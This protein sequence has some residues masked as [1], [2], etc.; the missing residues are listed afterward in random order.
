MRKL[1]IC[2]LTLSATAFTA[3]PASAAVE[4]P[5]RAEKS[6]ADS[7][8][9]YWDDL[10]VGDCHQYN[11]TLVLRSDGS[12]TWSATTT[13]DETTAFDIWHTDLYPKDQAG[14]VLFHAGEFDSQKML[15]GRRYHW[16]RDFRYDPAH[17]NRVSFVTQHSSC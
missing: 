16:A 7:R 12:A 4:A 1:T 15:P 2:A 13:T 8:S 9:F 10:K 6:A 17:Y 5:A 11:G 14:N 3:A